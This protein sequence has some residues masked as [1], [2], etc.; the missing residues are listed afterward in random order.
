MMEEGK[1]TIATRDASMAGRLDELCD[2]FE[3]AWKNG[4]APALEDYVRELP[5]ALAERGFRELLALDVAYRK[6]LGQTVQV[7]GYR[8]R[9]P[10][11]KSVI[12]AECASGSAPTQQAL[13]T[14]PDV[15]RI[16]SPQDEGDKPLAE[17]QPTSAGTP[18]SAG[19]RFR[20][21][22]PHAKGG[23]GEVLLAEDNELHRE[24][25]LKQIQSRYA[26]D[27]DSRA[28]FVLEA[29]VT[30]GLE[31]PGIV[32]VYGLG[33]YADGR[34]FYA[35]R[36][37]H[38]DSLKDAI[39]D[40]YDPAASPRDPGERTLAWRQLL[41]HFIAV[42]NAIEYAHSR[43][44]LH[45][46]LKPANIMLGKFG[47]TLVVDWGLAKALGSSNAAPDSVEQTLEPS[48]MGGS[49]PTQMG[50]AIGTPQF[51]SPEQASGQWN[52]VGPA[53]DIYSLGATL[54]CLLTGKPPLADC[55]GNLHQ[56]L[57]RV[58]RGEVP[59]PR[60]VRPDVPKALD[61]ICLKTMALDPAARY[62]SA[63]LLSEDI[64]HWLA[65]EPVSALPDTPFERVARW[66][67]RHRALALA[68][69]G[70]LALV[71]LVSVAA[72]VLVNQQRK[73]A[74]HLAHVNK[75]LADEQQGLRIQAEEGFREARA[76]VDDLFTKVSED[77]LLNQPGMQGL[78]KELLQ[79][80]LDYY[81]R[82]IKQHAQDPALQDEMG[83]TLFRAGRI[84]DDLKSPEQALPY[85]MRARD[86]QQKLLAEAPD[87]PARLKALGDTQ[88]AIG[89]AFDRGQ[90]YD[91]ALPPYQQAREIRQRL[92]NAAPQDAEYRRMLANT[93]MNIGL[94][95][96]DLG[97][98]DEAAKQLQAAQ[99]IRQALVISGGDSPKLQRD[100]AMGYYNQANLDLQRRRVAAAQ[101]N[102][103]AAIALFERL[104]RRDSH[105]LNLQ[106]QLAICY[107]L[108]GD[109]LSA[110]KANKESARL[111]GLARDSLSRL[112]DRNPDVSDYKATLAGV[113][114][115]LG[116][117]QDAAGALRSLGQARDLLTELVAQNPKHPQF[118]RDL[119]VTL[120]SL[121][122]GERDAGT[123]EVAQR[124]L[125]S[126][127]E[128]LTDL[129][130]KF[131][132]NADFADQLAKTRAAMR[133]SGQTKPFA[134]PVTPEPK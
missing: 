47:E 35:M 108:L 40:F 123:P 72:M 103:E 3:A 48:S 7:E 21:L 96:K 39:N 85:L 61:A 78:R 10:Q 55:A 71:T 117:K 115:N 118:R 112:V 6:K 127:F 38:G 53:S 64:E 125:K 130:A 54:Y 80:T 114:M 65:D 94:V 111:Y 56:I 91:E 67:R 107:R 93:V 106:Y 37:I 32:P 19:L 77:T 90:R 92:A 25:A 134:E 34:P 113:Y 50:T 2:R 8:A 18:T 68:A 16:Y 5:A 124:D 84:T 75:N 95:E 13:D 23:L 49:M 14:N 51:M 74:D 4:S 36:F 29:E 131:P 133:K 63:R 70:A 76:A 30:G 102:F 104:V 82:F 17:G 22:R 116:S 31:H 99:D 98:G 44:I 128:Y 59:P 46:D 41:S 79:K 12:E 119:A 66:T 45:R 81:E 101:K 11:Y 110:G 73:I 33:T 1:R 132:D 100:F 20:V 87:D 121:A 27:A 109:V 97:Q 120:R 86:L 89:R 26:D 60:Q 126:S 57:Y 105:D 24:V 9:F 69:A 28:R 129:S 43:G 83:V 122:A 58:Q 42:C 15:T 62:G 52:V 88:N